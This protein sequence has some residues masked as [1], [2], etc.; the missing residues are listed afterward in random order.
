MTKRQKQIYVAVLEMAHYFDDPA[1]VAEDL[2][3]NGYILTADDANV[4]EAACEDARFAL[5]KLAER[6]K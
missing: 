3:N 4:L 1:Q 5:R 2:E 6:A